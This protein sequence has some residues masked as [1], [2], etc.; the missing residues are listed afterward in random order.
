VD[1][2][3]HV[4]TPE[5]SDEGHVDHRRWNNR[6]GVG[7]TRE[8]M[9]RGGAVSPAPHRRWSRQV[10]RR[11]HS[12]KVQ[13]FDGSVWTSAS[14][15]IRAAHHGEKLPAQSA[16]PESQGS[17]SPQA[18]AVNQRRRCGS[19]AR[20]PRLRRSGRLNVWH[21]KA[22]ASAVVRHAIPAW[23]Q[24]G[25]RARLLERAGLKRAD[26]TLWEIT[27]RSPPCPIAACR[28]YGSNE[29]LVN[30]SGSGCSLGHPIG[31]LGARMVTTLT[32]RT[33]RRPASASAAMCAGVARAAR[34]IEGLA[35]D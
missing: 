4:E 22:W 11:D 23:A 10:P 12:L 1:A 18:T 25:D 6:P 34:C 33:E 30:F 8:E 19:G 28:E 35:R 21:R 26:V 29:E 32:L 14:M 13:Q 5:G 17:R 9:T 27:R 2:A 15:S 3:T 24:E 16:D 31:G 7:I 20:R